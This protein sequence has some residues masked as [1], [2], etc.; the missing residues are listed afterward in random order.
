MIHAAF[1][2]TE[3]IEW[4]LELGFWSTKWTVWSSGASTVS[5]WVEKAP[6]QIIPGVVIWVST[7]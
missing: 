6:L 5:T 1:Q 2:R 4:N 3:K 7:V